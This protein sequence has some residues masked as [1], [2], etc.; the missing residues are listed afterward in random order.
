MSTKLRLK[1]P[2][3]TLVISSDAWRELL[4][5]AEINGWHSEHPSACYWADIGLEVTDIDARRLGRSLE[6]LGDYLA[7]N[8]RRHPHEDLSELIGDL[9]DLAAFCTAG[10]FRVC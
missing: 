2:S 3:T 4:E 7:E 10:G 9:G 8:Q 5:I 1:G 6:I